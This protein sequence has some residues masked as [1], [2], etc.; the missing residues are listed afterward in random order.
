M[1]GR[2][3][4]TDGTAAWGRQR[5]AVSPVS[6]CLRLDGLVDVSFSSL[7]VLS[8]CRCRVNVTWSESRWN[9]N[10]EVR[11]QSRRLRVP[12]KCKRVLESDSEGGWFACK[13]QQPQPL[14]VGRA[15]SRPCGGSAPSKSPVAQWPS[16]SPSSLLRCDATARPGCQATAPSVHD[17]CSGD[18]KDLFPARAATQWVGRWAFSVGN[19]DPG[20][21]LPR[22]CSLC[23]RPGSGLET[24]E[25][26]S[27]NPSH[28]SALPVNR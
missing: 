18:S 3:R 4:G 22:A 24:E 5:E 17:R 20:C 27:W 14:V 9:C 16:G 26:K 11:A 28:T 25:K 15:F 7:C 8:I 10:G 1:S 19:Q 6:L 2:G 21:S 13:T 23:S 12:S